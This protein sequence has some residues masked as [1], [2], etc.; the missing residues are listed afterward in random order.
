[1]AMFITLGLV[2]IS[3]LSPPRVFCIL[4]IFAYD[5]NNMLK[6]LLLSNCPQAQTAAPISYPS[7]PSTPALHSPVLTDSTVVG[8]TS[9]PSHMFA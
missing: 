1:M 7:L 4:L 6:F 8:I 5:N 3:Q 9:T 2:P